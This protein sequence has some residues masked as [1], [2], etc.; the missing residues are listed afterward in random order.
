MFVRLNCSISK[1][2][3]LKVTLK[4]DL[5]FYYKMKINTIVVGIL[6]HPPDFKFDQ[7]AEQVL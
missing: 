6:H 7:T 5:T 1:G 3:L 4:I 2:P